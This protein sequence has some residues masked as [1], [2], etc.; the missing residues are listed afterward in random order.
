MFWA[1]NRRVCVSD[2][3]VNEQGERYIVVPE[4][5]VRVGVAAKGRMST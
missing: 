2:H 3:T 4:F 5:I 1:L